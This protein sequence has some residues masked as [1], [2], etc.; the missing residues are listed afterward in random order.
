MTEVKFFFNVESK[1]LFACKLAKKAFTD[2][3]K[4]VVYSPEPRRA[5]EFDR[6]L[7]AYEQ[8]A[9]IPHVHADHALAG[10][11]PI[12]IATSESNLPHHEALLNLSDEPP[13]FFSRFEHLREIVSVNEDDRAMARERVKFYKSRGFNVQIQD[14]KANAG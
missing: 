6:Q 8:L 5:D 9:F 10:E 13:A 3:R 2:G 4:L 1:L 12:V 7:W 14:M 11:T